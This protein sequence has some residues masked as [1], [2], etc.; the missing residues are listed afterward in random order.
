MDSVTP[1]KPAQ[2]DVL[3]YE[4]GV[5]VDKNAVE[6]INDQIA[7]ARRLYNNVVAVI[8][9]IVTD[10]QTYVVDLAGDEA[11]QLQDE[12]NGLNEA[13]AAAK[14]DNNEDLMRDVAQER[15][16]KWKSLGDALKVVRKEHRATI[17]EKY[18]SRI[19]NNSRCETYQE[20]A[21]A[22]ADGLGFATATAVL[23]SALQAF[24]KSF[25]MGK[26]PRFATGV[27]ITQDTLTLQFT[28]AGGVAVQDLLSGRHSELAIQPSGG[29]GRRK[30]GEF[31]FRLGAAKAGVNAT[32]TWQY[33][34]PLPEGASIAAARLVRKKVG[35]DIRWALQLI[36]KPKDPIKISITHQR[37][38]L[39]AVH[40]GWAADTSG[41]RV[42]G[43]A[44]GP[45]PGLARVLNLPPE[46]E[47]ELDRSSEMMSKRDS[48]RDE[49]VPKVK[50]LE[51]LPI[52][53]VQD[54][55]V[56]A[57]IAAIRKLPV[58]HV[59][60][61][62]IHRLC[63][64]LREID[65]LPAWLEEWRK[66]DRILWQSATH[67]ARRARFARRDFY[68]NTAATLAANYESIL[69]EPL[70]LAAAAK[71]VDEKTGE[72]TEFAKKARSG[73]VVAAIYEFESA[74]RWAA[75]KAGSA[76]L[77]M[78]GKTASACSVCGGVSLE[79]DEGNS[80]ALHCNDCGADL[81]RKTNG[82]AIAWQL[83]NDVREEVVEK[84]WLDA[85]A[86]AAE[87]RTKKAERQSKMIEGRRLA[88][89]SIKDETGIGSRSEM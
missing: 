8:Q 73:R 22:V 2:A 17:Q 65:A 83:A 39:V 54:E 46:I 38:P 32:G 85:S 56:L 13:F 43:V 71:K 4:Y 37:K 68:R 7:K 6:A 29:C 86:D 48:S 40:F 28:V 66:A 55:V 33:H 12:I 42:A 81:D 24:K 63:R 57:E 49:M 16:I 80:Q 5:R 62:R 84:Y 36:V 69:I 27:E 60:I 58:Q 15:R 78:N 72:K 52:A 45:D 3:V 76:V 75:V 53:A 34:R 79:A 31:R 11:K 50:D 14:A 21:K 20:R 64:S 10:L 35:K 77:E 44:D 23:D 41:R 30:Y 59:A 70:D 51:M 88:R 74:I 9:G 26:S 89:T 1:A 19:G 18:L 82:A 87:R 25:T 67:I 47:A 61:S